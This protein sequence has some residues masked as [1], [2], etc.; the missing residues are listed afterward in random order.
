MYKVRSLR[1]GLRK[2]RFLYLKRNVWLECLLTMNDVR[3]T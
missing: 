3:Y 2:E 1:V